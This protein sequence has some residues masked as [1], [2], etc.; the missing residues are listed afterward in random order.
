MELRE[1]SGGPAF[2]YSVAL[3]NAL[4]PPATETVDRRAMK[5]GAIEFLPKPSCDEGVLHA[6][7]QAFHHTGEQLGQREGPMRRHCRKV[8]CPSEIRVS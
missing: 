1:C 7:E 4:R 5:A 3:C 6:I 2:T 8:G